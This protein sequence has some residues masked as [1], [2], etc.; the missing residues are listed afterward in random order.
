MR[1][2]MKLLLAAAAVLAALIVVTFQ[3]PDALQGLPAKLAPRVIWETAYFHVGNVAVTPELLTEVL[4]FLFLLTFATRFAR[5]FLSR[6]ILIHTS[7]DEGQRYAIAR[8]TG[9]AFFGI[10]L[11]VG[12][13]IIGLNL[14]SLA[15]LGGAF[16]IG[17]GFGLQNI[18]SNFASGLILLL[19]RPIKVGD[20][21][22]VGNLN[23]DVIRIGGRST[24]VRTNDN[25]IIIVPNAEFTTNRVTNWTANDRSV[26]FSF[27]I[28][29]AYGTN[30]DLARNLLLQIARQH[31]DVMQQ[32]APEVLLSSFGDS[33]VNL[34]LRVWTITQ[35]RTP[36]VLKSDLYFEI[37]RQFAANGI[38]IPFPQRDLH[39]KSMPQLHQ[40]A[41]SV[42]A[43]V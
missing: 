12:L 1:K 31:P 32:P 43:A 5:N 25:L 28:G 38:E 39:V 42:N 11:L 18:A 3:R 19:E 27:P 40:A 15:F 13:Q 30:L 4:I 41:P 24:W 14:N 20:R 16:G 2:G 17:L 6:E 34:D 23:G 36:S 9:Y 26:R 29:V 10:G 21:I 22:D 33:S 35:M 8:T 7:L 37:A